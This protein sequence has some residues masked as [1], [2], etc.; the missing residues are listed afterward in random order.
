MTKLHVVWFVASFAISYGANH[1]LAPRLDYAAWADGP[2]LASGEM[3][4]SGGGRTAI[5]LVD[6][7]VM[8][9]DVETMFG[10]PLAVRQLLLRGALGDDQTETDLELFVDLVGTEGRPVDPRS[11]SD[12]A[13]KGRALSI[14]P[15][16]LAGG[17]PSRVRLPGNDAPALVTQGTLT[18]NEALQLGPGI[19]RVR[20][21]IDIELEQASGERTT[22]FGRLAGRLVWDVSVER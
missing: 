17:P 20:G 19:W 22:L 5:K 8:T 13:F 7:R 21:D 16:A 9:A 3:T 6:L 14:V 1:A 4:V 18:L 15:R 12:E 2:T 10:K 11:R